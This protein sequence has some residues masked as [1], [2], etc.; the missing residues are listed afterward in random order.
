MCQNC[1]V[2]TAQLLIA[3]LKDAEQN[4]TDLNANICSKM[5]RSLTTDE[6]RAL[7]YTTQGV[8]LTRTIAET[9]ASPDLKG[10]AM[11]DAIEGLL[12][13]DPA[14]RVPVATLVTGAKFAHYSA[15]L[16]RQIAETFDRALDVRAERD[17]DRD[18]VRFIVGDVAEE[19]EDHRRALRTIPPRDDDED[20]TAGA[21]DEIAAFVASVVA[22]AA[23]RTNGASGAKVPT[24]DYRH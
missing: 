5:G 16:L 18:A 1:R 12:I 7:D 11:V 15:M 22:K 24:P 17:N 20:E 3:A 4:V 6:Q 19:I 2:A 21:G 23:A 13:T 8:V 10:R 9:F 14:T